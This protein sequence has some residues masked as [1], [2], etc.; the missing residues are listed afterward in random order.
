MQSSYVISGCL[1]S[2]L[3][4]L[5]IIST[6]EAK[7][8]SKAYFF[9]LHFSLLVLLS[10]RIFHKMLYLQPAPSSSTSG[11]KFPSSNQSPAKLKAVAGHCVSC[12]PEV[13]GWHWKGAVA[14]IYLVQLTHPGREDPP[15]QESSVFPFFSEE[16]RFLSL[17]HI[18]QNLPDTSLWIFNSGKS[19]RI[20]GFS[21]TLF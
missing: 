16:L 9:H 11:E 17:G 5:F 12:H 21:I 8:P 10:N 6:N 4:P 1:F 3:L 15:H 19:E 20:T 14:A 7:S 13:I 2:V 18:R